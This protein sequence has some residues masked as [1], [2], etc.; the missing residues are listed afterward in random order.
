MRSKTKIVPDGEEPGIWGT[1]TAPPPTRPRG[2]TPT[3]C[4]TRCT[5]CPD[6]TGAA[7]TSWCSARCSCPRASSRTPPTTVPRASRSPRSSP[8][9]SR[10]SVSSR[11]TRSSRTAGRSAGPRRA[12]TTRPRRVPTTAASA[13]SRS[14]VVT[15]SRPTP[16]PACGGAGHLGHQRRGHARPVGVPDRPARNRRGGRPDLDGPLPALPH[17]RGLRRERVHLGQADQGRLERRRLPHQLLD[18]S[19]ARGLR[20]DHRGLRGARR[21]GQGRGAPRPATA[22][23]TRSV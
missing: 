11:S 5:P 21:R 18:P 9:T 23:A 8:T 10:C 14:P 17:L 1:S 3:A 6:P 20:R 4:S 16:A 2:P 22:T 15:S 13:R 19:D 12:T 7:T